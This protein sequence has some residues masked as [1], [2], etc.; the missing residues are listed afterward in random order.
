MW[1]QELAYGFSASLSLP[2][3]PLPSLSTPLSLRMCMYVRVRVL[4]AR[5]QCS[6]CLDGKD[7]SFNSPVPV[8]L[9]IRQVGVIQGYGEVCLAVAPGFDD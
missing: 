7:I 4:Q 5:T 1:V 2:S 9:Q 3:C 6:R 8:I